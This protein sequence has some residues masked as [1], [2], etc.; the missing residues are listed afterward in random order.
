MHALSFVYLEQVGTSAEWERSIHIRIREN[1][2]ILQ[3]LFL[4]N[5]KEIIPEVMASKWF[6]F[7][8]W[9]VVIT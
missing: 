6:H 3:S 7:F 2:L 9:T 5:I 4:L 8:S 1:G